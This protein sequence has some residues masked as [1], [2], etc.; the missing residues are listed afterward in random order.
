MLD[1]KMDL[2]NIFENP[3]TTM[4]ESTRHSGEDIDKGFV[5]VSDQDMHEIFL[6]YEEAKLGYLYMMLAIT[7]GRVGKLKNIFLKF[8][9][10]TKKYFF[11]LT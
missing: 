6:E 11:D 7:G 2:E 8:F 9:F 5:N 10:Q 1:S 4:A 3:G